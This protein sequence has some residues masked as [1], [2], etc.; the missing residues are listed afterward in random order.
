VKFRIDPIKEKIIVTE[1]DG[2]EYRQLRTYLTRHVKGYRHQ[3]RFK[4]G[5][6]DG[7]VSYF[8]NGQIDLGLWREVANCCAQFGYSF[9]VENKADFPLDRD[10]TLESINIFCSEFFRD[11]KSNGGEFKPYE[12]QL[13]TI[14]KVLKNRYCITEIATGGGKSLVFST[15]LFY[16]LKHI[17]PDAKALLI[18]PSI[19]LVTQFYNDIYN[20]NLGESN[21]NAEPLDIKVEEIMSDKPRRTVDGE[22]NVYIG[23]YQSLEKWPAEWFKQFDIVAA[24][25]AHT[26]KAK[27]LIDVLGRTRGSARWRFGM[28]GT[29]PKEDSL[30]ILTIQALLGPKISEVKAKELMD[31]GVIS[32]VKIKSI[33]LNHE[34]PGF[35][36]QL[37]MIKRGRNGKACYDL[38]KAYI[39]K[40]DKRLRFIVDKIAKNVKKTTLVLFHTVEYGTRLYEAMRDTLDKEVYYIDGSVKTEKREW[41]KK[42]LEEGDGAKILVASFGTLS[43]GVSIR[44]IH[45]IVFADS[46]KSDQV[47]RQSIGRGLRL[48]K[49]KDKLILIDI[50]DQF[51]GGL[52]PTNIL[53]KHW[54]ERKSIYKEQEFEWDELKINL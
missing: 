24:D 25:E 20:Y 7:Q 30:E 48:H 34:D 33:Q 37:K 15:I 46:F 6:W 51:T 45:T 41:I 28:S 9:G 21:E 32:G 38:E 36:A 35:E 52:N 54:I 49:D 31:K 18:V 11:H 39:H 12:H 5:V 40:S 29:F 47:I 17:K 3:P 1:A 50:T 27:T 26:C 13:D 44:N 19:S 42:R 8:N 16:I 22:P 23:T 4:M 2:L 53:F 43:T 14:Y 10:I